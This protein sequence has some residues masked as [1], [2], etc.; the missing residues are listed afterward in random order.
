MAIR[1]RRL[2]LW[3]WSRADVW[4]NDRLTANWQAIDA[5]PGS[6]L[7][8]STERPA[9]D[10]RHAGRT[11]TETDTNLVWRWSGTAFARTGAVGLL[12]EAF[13]E[14]PLSTSDTVPQQAVSVTVA[15]P[16]GDRPILVVASG[17]GAHSTVGVS[18]ITLKR[19]ATTLQSWLVTGKLSEV[20][21]EQPNGLSM[22]VMDTPGF[23]GPVTYSVL[24]SVEPGFGGTSTIMADSV[25]RLRIAAVEV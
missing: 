5:A 13:E 17:P 2:G 4:R 15:V 1:T 7:C 6:H 21:E 12:G 22:S 9:W 10:E 3:L 8:L 24:I 23:S 25:N 11:I 16:P 20:P 19:D 14:N 18:R